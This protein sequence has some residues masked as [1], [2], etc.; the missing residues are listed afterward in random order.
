MALTLRS[1]ERLSA[2]AEPVSM[3]N[4]ANNMSKSLKLRTTSTRLHTPIRMPKS[5][6]LSTVVSEP[7]G[8]QL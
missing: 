4:A 6:Y 8:A 3:S 5:D 7:E 1:Q 2:Q